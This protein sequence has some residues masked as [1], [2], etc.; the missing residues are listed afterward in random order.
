MID[1]YSHYVNTVL[2]TEASI[3]GPMDN[4]KECLELFNNFNSQIMLHCSCKTVCRFHTCACLQKSGGFNYISYEESGKIKYLL[5]IGIEE[6]PLYMECNDMCTC[7]AQ[8][9]NRLVQKGPVDGLYVKPCKIMNK[10]LG[11]Y[12][13]SFLL[14]GTFVCEYAGELLTKS[15][16][17]ARYKNN[18]LNGMSNYI[19]CLNEYSNG[20]AL[21]TF[22]DPSH[23]G[24]IGRY[25][26]HSCN[27]NCQVIPVRWNSPIPKLAI[28]VSLD[29]APG[30]ELTFNYGAHSNHS[31]KLGLTTK[32]VKC[33]C[34]SP[35]CDG[36]MPYD[37]YN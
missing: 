8:C 36:Y 30:T 16:A 33:L 25:I 10:G 24:N 19:F 26:N 21:Q 15:Q 6:L 28:F 4:T 1:N 11:L 29:V 37:Y 18:L 31:K 32:L 7:G 3:P 27:P 14:K 5:N 9:G 13:S 12:T 17:I 34:N 23:F 2:Y 20:N 22:V 35:N